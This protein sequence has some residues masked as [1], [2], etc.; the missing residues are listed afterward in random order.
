M[1]SMF[2]A[3]NQRDWDE[4]LPL[5]T[6]AYRSTPQ[7]S[8]GFTP[9]LLMYLRELRLPIDLMFQGPPG[10]AFHCHTEF[11]D[12]LRNVMTSAY[13]LVRRNLKKSAVR[14]K[15]HYDVGVKKRNLAVGS[16][17]WLFNPA[18]TKGRSPKL[19]IKWMGPYLVREKIGVLC[20]IQLSPKSRTRVVHQDRL[21]AYTGQP[22]QSWIVQ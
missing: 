4:K 15:F 12:N 2:V 18:K 10:E 19:S 16:F 3:Q 14:Q 20:K 13:R 5:L 6:M 8:T 7:A 9:N 22:R 17:V 11:V 21:L 1:L